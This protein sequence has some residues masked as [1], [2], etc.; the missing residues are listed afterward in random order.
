V[1]FRSGDLVEGL[2]QFLELVAHVDDAPAGLLGEL[3][4]LTSTEALVHAA[5]GDE[6]HVHHGIR[7]LGSL[8]GVADL[9]AAALVLAVGEQDH[10]LAADLAR[11]LFIGGK[12]DGVVEQSAF[13]VADGDGTAAQ[14]GQAS[15]AAAAVD[16]RAIHA[17]AQV[18]RVV[19]EILQQV[20]VHVEADDER[21]V[22]FAQDFARLNRQ[23]MMRMIQRA[24]ELLSVDAGV[25]RQWQERFYAE[26][27]SYSAM[28]VPNFVKL[29]DAYGAKGFRIEKSKD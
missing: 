8:D 19:G 7:P 4:H 14:A 15:S 16:A 1:L 11:Q 25:R 6:Q 24:I 23:V 2:L 28:A 12:I 13:R 29:A 21:Q 26:R 3:L 22:L 20:N 27:Y 17:G 10:G 5:V 18:T 9:Q